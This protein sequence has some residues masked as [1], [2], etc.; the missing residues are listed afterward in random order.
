MR[1]A[2]GQF[3]FDRPILFEPLNLLIDLRRFVRL[4]LSWNDGTGGHADEQR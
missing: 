4:R 1:L 3:S 2:A